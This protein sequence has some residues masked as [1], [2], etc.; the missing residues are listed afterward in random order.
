VFVQ[1]HLAAVVLA[2][3]P[4]DVV[5]V[6]EA[7]DGGEGVAEAE[8]DAAQESAGR[9]GGAGD[10]AAGEVGVDQAL[11]GLEGAAILLAEPAVAQCAAFLLQEGFGDAR[12]SL[13]GDLDAEPVVAAPGPGVVE[14]AAAAEGASRPSA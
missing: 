2:G 9:G 11:Q 5:A 8:V 12:D 1:G 4:Q 10:D 3:Q 14:E 7:P 6:E 13:R